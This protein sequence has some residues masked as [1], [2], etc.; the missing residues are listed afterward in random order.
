MNLEILLIMGA[1]FIMVGVALYLWLSDDWR[2]EKR[3]R[4]LEEITALTEDLH[5]K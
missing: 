1:T 5:G 4:Y 3:L 2:R